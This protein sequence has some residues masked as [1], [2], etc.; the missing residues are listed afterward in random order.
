LLMEKGQ[1]I[2]GEK[3]VTLL[4]EF[5]R[6]VL[7][8]VIVVHQPHIVNHQYV[9]NVSQLRIVPQV[10]FV[11]VQELVLL[12]QDNFQCATF[13]TLNFLQ[14]SLIYIKTS[15]IYI[16]FFFSSIFGII[17]GLTQSPQSGSGNVFKSFHSVKTK[18]S[19]G[20]S[21]PHS[22]S[23]TTL[24]LSQMERNVFSSSPM[25]SKDPFLFGFDF[26]KCKNTLFLFPNIF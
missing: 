16:S 13:G 7:P 18:R 6:Y 11:I 21:A 23:K 2:G 17:S 22:C 19:S 10:K 8:I 14:R 20:S 1:E 9:Y 12:L 4:E 3:F 26:L 15:I 5:A 24:K 25:I